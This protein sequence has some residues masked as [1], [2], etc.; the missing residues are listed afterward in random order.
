MQV[1]IKRDGYGFGHNWILQCYGKEFWLGQDSKFCGRVLGLRPAE[2][3]AEIGTDQ[4]E[5]V[6]GNNKLAKFICKKLKINRSNAGQFN[7]WDFSVQ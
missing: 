2:V 5:T 4:I 6:C 3:V 1:L 7:S